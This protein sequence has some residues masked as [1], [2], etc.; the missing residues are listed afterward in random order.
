MAC[1]RHDGKAAAIQTAA[2]AIATSSTTRMY[3]RSS[4]P[5]CF[6]EVEPT[7]PASAN[8]MSP[9]YLVS[10]MAAHRP[11][12]RFALSIARTAAILASLVALSCDKMPLVAPT[13]TAITL[14]SATNVLPVNGFAEITA[15]LI[16][17]VQ[18]GSG[19]TAGVTAGGGTPVHNGTVVT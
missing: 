14:V 7:G 11:Q 17:G 4:N 1:W 15:F 19:T 12:V 5:E 18:S 2:T 6:G 8:F 16:Q 9:V 10:R 3:P 13:G